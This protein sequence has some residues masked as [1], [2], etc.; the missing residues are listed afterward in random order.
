MK[1]LVAL[2]LAGAISIGCQKKVNITPP[3]SRYIIDQFTEIVNGSPCLIKNYDTNKDKM[4]D[5]RELYKGRM[6]IAKNGYFIIYDRQ[7]QQYMVDLDKD[8]NMDGIY[9]DNKRDGFNGNE[10]FLK[11]LDKKIIIEKKYGIGFNDT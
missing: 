10:I 1:K 3:N 2:L 11:Y 8:G 7:P 6:V 4:V 5:F 9:L